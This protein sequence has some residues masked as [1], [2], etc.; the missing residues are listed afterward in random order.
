MQSRNVTCARRRDHYVVGDHLCDP[1]LEPA[2]TQSCNTEPCPAEWFVGDWG[3]CSKICGGGTQFRQVYC[4]QVVSNARPSVIDDEICLEKVGEKPVSEVKC[5]EGLVCP[6][7]YI[8]P[9]R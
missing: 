5:N 3:N 6:T 7:W 1:A 9:W 8:G 4:Q 2:R